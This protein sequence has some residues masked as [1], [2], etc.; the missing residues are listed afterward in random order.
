MTLFHVVDFILGI[1]AFVFLAFLAFAIVAFVIRML[2]YLGMGLAAVGYAAYRVVR[3]I[4]LIPVRIV[5]GIAK[6]FRRK[7]VMNPVHV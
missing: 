6:L 7:N 4:L 5:Q 1:A 3:F 2:L